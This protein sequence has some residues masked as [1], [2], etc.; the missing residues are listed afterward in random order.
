MPRKGL[1][2]ERVL[3]AAASLVDREGLDALTLTRLAE[4][5]EVRPPSLFNHFGSLGALHKALALKGTADLAD[6]LEAACA[7]AARGRR[8]LALLEA[9]RA[10]VLAHPGTY[11]ASFKV[12]R[13]E[14]FADENFRR[15]EGRIMELGTTILEPYGLGEAGTIHALRGI[16]SLAH[17]FAGI[18]GAGGFGLDLDRDLS[19][20]RLGELFVAGL[21]RLAVPE[22]DAPPGAGAAETTG[23]EATA[24]TSAPR[25][26][27]AL[28]AKG[29]AQDR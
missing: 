19:Y 6:R 20:R 28:G 9:Y 24:E 27:E 4:L 10:Y 14:A 11:A 5:L 26:E 23:G 12:S 1:T 25:R 16:R 17:G 8:I 15:E 2:K 3:E 21:E 29:S 13:P 22:E 18:E 7:G